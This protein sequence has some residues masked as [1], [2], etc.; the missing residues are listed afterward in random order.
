MGFT[1][2]MLELEEQEKE[3]GI[4][5][6]TVVVCSVT[7]SSQAGIIVGS[8]IQK[9]EGKPARR[10]IGIDA[11]AKPA[12]TKAQ[13]RKIAQATADKLGL[14]RELTEDEVELD[15]RFHA[16]VYGLAD[17]ETLEAM[18]LGARTD[19][20]VTDPVYEGKSLAGLIK[21]VRDGEISKES[22]VLYVHLGG[23]AAISAYPDLIK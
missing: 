23:Q 9:D 18:K 8:A 19:G 17:E 5:F 10:V 12:Q 1:G 3:L 14:G 20:M 22:N 21:L 4:H 7:G 11:S 15:E 2:F 6:D 16:G 13:V